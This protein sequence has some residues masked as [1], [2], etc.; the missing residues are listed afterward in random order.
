MDT[1]DIQA[2]LVAWGERLTAAETVVAGWLPQAQ[3][4]ALKS[5]LVLSHF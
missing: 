4:P 3:L 5:A 1:R 2:C